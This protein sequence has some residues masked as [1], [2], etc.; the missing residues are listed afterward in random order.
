MAERSVRDFLV[1]MI[2]QALGDHPRRALVAAR[3]LGE[4]CEW[5]VQRAVAVA[6]DAGY[7]WGGSADSSG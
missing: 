6:R 3:C 2:D 4:D 1:D 7:S 5:L